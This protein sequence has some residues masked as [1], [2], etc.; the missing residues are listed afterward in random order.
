MRGCLRTV[1]SDTAERQELS[2]GPI[3]LTLHSSSILYRLDERVNFGALKE[4]STPRKM[5]LAKVRIN[6]LIICL[7][8]G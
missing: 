2:Q 8:V 6:S 5:V 1:V 4:L 7:W 3:Q